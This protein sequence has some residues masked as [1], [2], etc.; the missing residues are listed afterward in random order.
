MEIPEEKYQLTPVENNAKP[1]RRRKTKSHVWKYFTVES[2]SPECKRAFCNTCRKSF[3][4][5]MVQENGGSRHLEKGTCGATAGLDNNNEGDDQATPYTPST[6]TRTTARVSESRK[7][8]YRSPSS[9]YMAVF[10]PDVC[11]QDIARMIIMHDYPLDMV[12][13]P[14]F[15]SFVQSLQPQFGAVS[16]DTIQGECVSSYLSE[17]QK[18][19][20]LIDAMPGRVCLSLDMRMS[21]N[22]LA[23]VFITGHFTDSNWKTQKWILNV[24]L[25]P[26]PDSHNAL[27]HAVACCLSDWRLESKLLSLTLNHPVPEAG[28]ENLR[29]HLCVKNPLILKGQLLLGQCI[30]HT[31]T[32]MVNDILSAGGDIIKKI[33]DNIK[34]VTTSENHGE[35]FLHLKEQLQVPSEVHLFLDDKSQ[36]NTTYQMLVSASELQEVFSC[37]DTVIPEYKEAP[38]MEDWKQVESLCTHLRSLFDA[39]NLL[40][41]SPSPPAITL[42]QEGFRI[43][44]T[45]ACAATGDPFIGSFIK[46]MQEKIDKYWK[47]CGLILAISVVMDPRFKMKLVEFS[48]SKLF[49]EESPLYVK[50]VDDGLHEL[51]EE[52]VALPLPP[53]PAYGGDHGNIDRA[54][55]HNQ[56]GS[57]SEYGLADFDMYIME[58][59]TQQFKSEIDQYLDENLEG[60]GSNLDVLE[61]WKQKRSKYPTMSKMARDI[62]SIPVSTTLP[63]S[64]FSTKPRELSPNARSETLEPFVCTKDWLQ[65]GLTEDF[66]GLESLVVSDL[67]NPALKVEF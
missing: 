57:I 40:V 17:K 66:G 35:K 62:L 26:Y 33:R 18:V 49:G 5:S 51:F 41:S 61:W 56:G 8:R 19:M 36:W 9:A 14:G 44:T 47:E 63:E 4:Y 53:S 46:S 54:E 10:N 52:Y 1:A 11:R 21:R 48:F 15:Q 50:M 20:R 3:A 28:L 64:M 2:I 23:Y 6:R 45:I 34:Y 65:H 12:E 58:N 39:M 29:S 55:E 31:F 22:S 30:S 13:H 25:E 38:T 16:I 43:Q 59:T 32:A 27:S 7:R 37:L 24:V 67:S 60:R 42:F